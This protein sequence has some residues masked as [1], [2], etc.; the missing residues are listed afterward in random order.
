LVLGLATL[1]PLG[2]FLP[3]PGTWGS[4][5]GVLLYAAFFRGSGSGALLVGTALAAWVAAGLCGEAEVRLRQKDPGGVILDEVIALPLCFLGWGE[6][7]GSHP[8]LLVLIAGFSLFRYYDIFKP[9]GISRL[10]Q[11]P[12]GWGVVGD[13]LGAA[14]ATAATLHVGHWVW[15]ALR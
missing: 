1:G 5:V 8:P 10:Q 4:L 14:L 3:A 7:A 6:L 15:L 9:L 12:G 13:D 11:L 2:R